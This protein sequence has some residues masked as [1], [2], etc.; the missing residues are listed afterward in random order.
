MILSHF[1]H[2]HDYVE[3]GSGDARAERDGL[4]DFQN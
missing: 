4:Q 3:Y 1:P 2:L